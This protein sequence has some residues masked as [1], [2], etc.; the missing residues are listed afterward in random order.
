MILWVSSTV[1]SCN[2]PSWQHIC[3]GLKPDN[4]GEGEVIFS[5]PFGFLEAGIDIEN[6][7]RQGLEFGVY[8]AILPFFPWIQKILVSTT[9][10]SLKLLPSNFLIEK[11]VRALNERKKNPDARYDYVAHWLKAHKEQ[12]DKLTAKDV[13]AAV[14][15]NVRYLG[16]L[17]LDPVR[18]SPTDA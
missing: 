14:S 15:S 17:R 3:D 18:S 1:S 7:L 4:D 8:V 16:P 5:K 13:Q 11:S 10:A 9:F 6:S 2:A 12:P